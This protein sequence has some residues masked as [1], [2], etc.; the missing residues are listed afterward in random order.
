MSHA[1]D[2]FKDIF[3][4]LHHLSKPLHEHVAQTANYIS[5]S[6]LGILDVLILQ[7]LSRTR[8]TLSLAYLLQAGIFY[9]VPLKVFPAGSYERS[10]G[11]C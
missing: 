8:F 11:G 1:L 3:T 7:P 10:Y 5:P 2:F 4:S 9:H 6:R